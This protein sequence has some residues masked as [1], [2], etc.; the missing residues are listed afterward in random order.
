MI[1][2]SPLSGA[3]PAD[4]GPGS[5]RE[6]EHSWAFYTDDDAGH[7]FSKLMPCETFELRAIREL[8]RTIDGAPYP[9]LAAPQVGTIDV[10]CDWRVQ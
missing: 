1:C 3:N 7:C 8:T 9:R 5:P 4:Y 10:P 2:R 6:I